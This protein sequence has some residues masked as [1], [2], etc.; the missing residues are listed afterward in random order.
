MAGEALEHSTGPGQVVGSQQKGPS[1][2]WSVGSAPCN[3]YTCPAPVCLTVWGPLLYYGGKC[4]EVNWMGGT[5]TQVSLGLL[6]VQAREGESNLGPPVVRGPSA[7]LWW[8]RLWES[9]TA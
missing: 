4:R 3:R 7:P 8:S 6:S 1:T 9:R 2:H 5:N